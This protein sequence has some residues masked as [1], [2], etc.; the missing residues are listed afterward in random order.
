MSL[1]KQQIKEMLYR[2][3]ESNL[4]VTDKQI[5]AQLL[6]EYYNI[7]KSSN[8]SSNKLMIPNIIGINNGI[9][10]MVNIISDTINRRINN[11]E[12]SQVNSQVNS[13]VK[14]FM[15]TESYTNVNGEQNKK[16]QSYMLDSNGNWRQVIDTN[17][18]DILNKIRLFPIL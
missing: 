12:N 17:K 14:G 16:Q 7:N 2:L 3:K 13:H 11:K 6:I 1:R 10:N 4:S 18:S 15:R 9:S 8:K 5:Y